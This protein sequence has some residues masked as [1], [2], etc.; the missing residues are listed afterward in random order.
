MSADA[1][2]PASS[3]R[4]A[5]LG[6]LLDS[7]GSRYSFG[8]EKYSGFVGLADAA[9]REVRRTGMFSI[10][11]SSHVSNNRQGKTDDNQFAVP[12]QE[13][14]SSLLL[15][16]MFYAAMQVVGAASFSATQM[17]NETMTLYELDK[18]C[19]DFKII[20]NMLSKSEIKAVWSIFASA[21]AT[22]KRQNL[23]A[24]TFE[25]FQDLFVRMA[26][27][28]Y[29]KRGMK[30][31]IE[32][33]SGSFPPPEQLVKFFCTYCHLDDYSKVKYIIRTVGMATQ[34]ALN[35]RSAN[36]TNLRAR[37][38]QLIDLRA[39]AVMRQAMLE[40]K[41]Q[42]AEFNRHKE[43]KKKKE[44]ALRKSFE[45]SMLTGGNAG[46]SKAGGAADGTMLPRRP[47][48]KMS[49]M[50][51]LR[52]AAE[53]GEW[54]QSSLPQAVL[55]MVVPVSL[56]K[57]NRG[58]A[59]AGGAR[60]GTGTLAGSPLPK[61]AAAAR[62]EAATGN[63]EKAAAGGTV[64]SSSSS[65]STAPMLVP[66]PVGDDEEDED[67]EEFKRDDDMMAGYHS[68]LVDELECYSFNEPGVVE[69]EEGHA[70]GGPFLDMGNVAPSSVC[71]VTIHTTN[72]LPD[73]VRIDV[74]A[75]NF[76]AT[77]DTSVKTKTKPIVPGMS[78]NHLVS[79]TTTDVI[80]AQVGLVTFV[81]ISERSNCRCEIICPVFY[82][83]DPAV[84]P[85]SLLSMRTLPDAKGRFLGAW[86]REELRVSFEKQRI[87]ANSFFAPPV[88][89][90]GGRA[91]GS[92]GARPGTTGAGQRRSSPGAGAGKKRAVSE[93]QTV[94]MPPL[95]PAAHHT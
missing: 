41:E 34:G 57:A 58:A 18:F 78:R 28:A 81:G 67:D 48:A 12:V 37:E 52:V 13:K 40:A 75:R 14:N 23:V 62:T 74:L 47:R 24:M 88:G 11:M 27:F 50:D 5:Q 21:Y 15:V 22:K 84:R 66:V 19:R 29:N 44:A 33:V 6:L 64:P 31:M 26:L 2:T 1:P 43:E 42:E 54:R 86:A 35:Y 70:S 77:N 10:E 17:A 94:R 3:G 73:D 79:F 68:K 76:N 20:P 95:S 90:P 59:T 92:P 30:R 32:A 39:K 80:G 61:G 25:D 51:K 83:V 56:A 38:E 65:S 55:D 71:T 63:E 93:G 7:L 53:E 87:D 89:S 16:F 46:G 91:V 9:V 4:P 49:K 85:R 36:E 45:D 8:E 72:L 69:E 82:R 60:T